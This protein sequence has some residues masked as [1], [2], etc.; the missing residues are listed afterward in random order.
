LIDHRPFLLGVLVVR[1][2]T[3]QFVELVGSDLLNSPHVGI[4][5]GLLAL[6]DE[7]IN[8]TSVKGHFTNKY[9][10]FRDAYMLFAKCSGERS[11]LCGCC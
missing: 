2:S 4:N 5:L 9:S 1:Q 3:F 6:G 7:H 11:I 10:L 8:D